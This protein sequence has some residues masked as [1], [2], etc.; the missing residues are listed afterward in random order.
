MFQ[1]IFVCIHAFKIYT[2]VI[3][4]KMDISAIGREKIDMRDVYITYNG[5]LKLLR[6]IRK[7]KTV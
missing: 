6:N 4:C 2:A 7:E 1:V 5:I 3:K